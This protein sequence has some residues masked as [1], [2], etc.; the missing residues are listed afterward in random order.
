M[1]MELIDRIILIFGQIVASVVIVASFWAGAWVCRSLI[2]RIGKFRKVNVDVIEILGQAAYGG[3]LV[4]GFVTGLGT[5]G[6]D[7]SALIAGLGLTSLALGLALRDSV[8]NL[9]AGLMI[10]IYRPFQRTDRIWVDDQTGEV[11]N[12]TLRYTELR[13][14]GKRIMIPNAIVFTKTVIVYDEPLDEADGVA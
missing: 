11:Q 4:V 13:A 10:L 8:S 14:D 2:H 5:L 6:I 12:I 3:L 1:L 7:T 9:I